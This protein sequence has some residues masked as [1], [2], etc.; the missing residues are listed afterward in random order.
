MSDET[1]LLIYDMELYKSDLKYF[2]ISLVTIYLW[3]NV[4]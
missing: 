3:P 1:L 4:K 2:L